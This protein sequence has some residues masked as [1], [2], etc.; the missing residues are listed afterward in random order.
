MKT[1][2]LT[3]CFLLIVAGLLLW[4]NLRIPGWVHEFR[5]NTNNPPATLDPITKFLFFRGWPFTP[6]GYCDGNLSGWHPERSSGFVQSAAFADVVIFFLVLAIAGVLCESYWRFWT[7]WRWAGVPLGI[8]GLVIAG[9]LI[10]D[11]DLPGVDPGT[12]NAQLQM[13]GLIGLVSLVPL[14]FGV[15][16]WVGS[17]PGQSGTGRRLESPDAE[18]GAAPDR[19]GNQ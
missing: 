2:F 5:F 15:G 4:L 17:W 8:A 7:F 11:A 14:G 18:A 10:R 9:V 12:R 3:K 13:A 1:S 16:A 19:G 6:C